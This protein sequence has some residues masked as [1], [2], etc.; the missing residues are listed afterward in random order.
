MNTIPDKNFILKAYHNI[1]NYIHR[2]PI[3]TSDYFT[4]LVGAKN[5]YFKCENVQKTGSFK[6]RGAINAVSMHLDNDPTLSKRGFITHSSGNHAG[7]LASVGKILGVPTIVVMPNNSQR[8]KIEAVKSYGAEIIF[9]EPDLTSREKT[10]AKIIEERDMKLIHPYDDYLTIAGQSTVMYE[11][12][13]DIDDIDYVIAPVGGGGLLCG[14]LLGAKYFGKSDLKVIA[15][16]PELAK[17]AYLSFKNKTL[18]KPFPPL[19]VADG[20]RTGLGVRNFEIM[21]KFLDD[22]I[23]VDEDEI[24]KSMLKVFERMKLVIEPS[25]ATAVAAVLKEKERFKNKNVAI[26]LSGGNVDLQDLPFK[27]I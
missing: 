4:K 8:V 25:S 6:F 10:T 27:N 26:I 7:A 13:Y 19:T 21:L 12:L 14:C 24:I 5:I 9:C 15:A 22:I 20:L 18:Y 3:L 2:T 23:L 1:K 16:E 17:D 11:I